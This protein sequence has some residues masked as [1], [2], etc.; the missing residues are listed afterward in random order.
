[1][2]LIPRS[3]GTHLALSGTVQGGT[4]TFKFRFPDL[5]SVL[6]PFTGKRHG[7]ILLTKQRQSG[8]FNRLNTD[9]SE[10]LCHAKTAIFTGFS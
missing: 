9:L 3:L 10:R 2:P 4:K 8:K 6:A 7:T 1:M 5:G